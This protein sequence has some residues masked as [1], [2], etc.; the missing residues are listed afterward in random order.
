MVV[1]HLFVPESTTEPEDMYKI[2][3]VVCISTE[4]CYNIDVSSELA[5]LDKTKLKWLVADQMKTVHSVSEKTTLHVS[6]EEEFIIEIG[7][8]CL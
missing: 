3:H 8:R 6:S 1:Y 2:P 7:P 4:F 5:V